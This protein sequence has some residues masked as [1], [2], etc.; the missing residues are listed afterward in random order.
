MDDY[1]PSAAEILQAEYPGWLVWR[2]IREGG[3]HGDWCAQPNPA[4]PA[5]RHADIEGLAELMDQ[6]TLES[7]G[8]A[9]SAS[10]ADG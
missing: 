2:E 6:A 9:T 3:G 7:R 10:R 1:G 4:A 5:L 8:Q